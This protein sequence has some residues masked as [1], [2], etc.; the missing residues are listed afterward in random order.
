M[1]AVTSTELAVLD[2]VDTSSTLKTQLDAKLTGAAG[3]SSG[4]FISCGGSVADGEYLKV[5]GTTLEGRTTNELLSDVGITN[6]AVSVSANA[7][8]SLTT[9]ND[10]DTITV[11]KGMWNAMVELVNELR[12][13][14]HGKNIAM[15]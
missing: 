1:S 12:S 5:N 4:N 2:G 13:Q 8:S 15:F 7:L 9:G 14:L 11:T 10:S 3:I 6:T